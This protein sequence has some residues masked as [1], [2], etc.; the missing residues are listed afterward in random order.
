MKEEYTLNLPFERTVA[1]YPALARHFGHDVNTAL[2]FQQILFWSDKGDREDGFIYKTKDEFEEETALTSKQQDRCR[3]KLEKL[4]YI[5][6]KK[7][8]VNGSPTLHYRAKISL[9]LRNMPKGH[10]G[11]VPLGTLECDQRGYSIIGTEMTTDIPVGA[12][13]P[14]APAGKK[15]EQ[16]RETNPVDSKETN[17]TINRVLDLFYE[18]NPTLDYIKFRSHVQ[19]LLKKFGEDE[20]LRMTREAVSCHGVNFAPTVT[21]PKGLYDRWSQLTAYVKKRENRDSVP[22]DD[23]PDF[24]INSW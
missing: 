6:V 15:D 3:A 21:D 12:A 14:L 1:F 22:S 20:T 16:E 10:I 8:R 13:A 23:R 11:I 4:D 2:Y 9:N 18:I 7:L 5:E 24:C 19:K 17:K